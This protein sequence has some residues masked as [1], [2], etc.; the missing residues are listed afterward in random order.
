M[1]EF[2]GLENVLNFV[3]ERRLD[4]FELIDDTN[5]LLIYLLLYS[6]DPLEQVVSFLLKIALISQKVVHIVN[7]HFHLLFLPGLC[8]F[9]L[10]THV[11]AYFVEELDFLHSLA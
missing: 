11:L 10:M 7:K 5:N 2:R 3:H 8:R 9:D 6:S 4:A 1:V